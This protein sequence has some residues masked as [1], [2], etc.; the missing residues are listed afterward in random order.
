MSVESV[1]SYFKENHI[2]CEI[3]EMDQTTETVEIAA[4]V[5]GVEPA[6][7]AKTLFLFG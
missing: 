3:M 1:K 4:R 5:L 7:I 6:L 2:S